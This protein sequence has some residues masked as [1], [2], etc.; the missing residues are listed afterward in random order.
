[1]FGVDHNVSKT[2]PHRDVTEFE[3]RFSGRKMD[4]GERTIV[5]IHG[6]DGKR[7]FY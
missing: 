4:D 1:M 3:F 6:A 5:A 2:R 7:A